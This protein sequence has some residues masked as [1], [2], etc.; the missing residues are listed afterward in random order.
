VDACLLCAR[1][2]KVKPAI[3]QPFAW[4]ASSA[5]TRLLKAGRSSF[6]LRR[7]TNSIA[8]ITLI[9]NRASNAESC[10]GVSTPTL[11]MGDRSARRFAENERGGKA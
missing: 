1:N 9:S 11:R 4:C 8:T 3:V 2:A 6:V 10:F 7:A 5:A